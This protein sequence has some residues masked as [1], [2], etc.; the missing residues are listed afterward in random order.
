MTKTI[1]IIG[2][3]WSFPPKIGP[4]GGVALASSYNDV[5]QA[6]KIILLTP[7]GQRVMRPDF[8]CRIHELVFAPMNRETFAQA[9]RYVED[10]LEMWEPRII[11]NDI[12]LNPDSNQHGRLFIDIQ[13]TLRATSDR[14][15]LV[16]PFYLI[17]EE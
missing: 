8:G 5:E 2:A 7:P 11:V 9:A 10:A 17:P 12:T 13:Y 3:G 14:R 6:I 15:S 16:F 1:D 4:Q